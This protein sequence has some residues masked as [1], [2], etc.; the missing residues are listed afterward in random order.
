MR[1]V[2]NA[3]YGLFLYREKLPKF[4]NYGKMVFNILDYE[5]DNETPK[6]HPTQKSIHLLEKLIRIFT[7]EGD[8]VIDP[9]AGSGTTILAAKR[10]GFNC[11]GIEKEA[12]Y[13]TIA[14]ARLDAY[15]PEPQQM[16]LAL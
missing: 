16:E 13:V 10:L 5:R 14:Q 2:G 1:I 6:I 4:N 11:I 3:E 12:E 8:V 7:D 9:V 15:T